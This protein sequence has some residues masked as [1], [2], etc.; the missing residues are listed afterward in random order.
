[1]YIYLYMY[2]CICVYIHIYIYIYTSTI[3]II[4]YMRVSILAKCVVFC[5]SF[6]GNL[7]KCAFLWVFV[8]LFS[9]AFWGV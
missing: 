2:I 1:M 8:G 4:L 7:W 3:Y 9:P 6:C 5:Y